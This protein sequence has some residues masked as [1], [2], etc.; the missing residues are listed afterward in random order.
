M[1]LAAC[2]QVDVRIIGVD[3]ERQRVSLSMLPWSDPAEAPANNAGAPGRQ[4]ANGQRAPRQRRS[5][6]APKFD[7]NDVYQGARAMM[8][9]DEDAPTLFEHAWAEAQQTA[10]A[11]GVSLP[12]ELLEED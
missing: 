4:S 11:K 12:S 1:C 6:D 9:E 3:M 10:A 2:A 8:D 5:D 7:N